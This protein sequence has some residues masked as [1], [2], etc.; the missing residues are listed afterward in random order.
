[1]FRIELHIKGFKCD[2]EFSTSH[3]PKLRGLIFD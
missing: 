2:I 1:L 3:N